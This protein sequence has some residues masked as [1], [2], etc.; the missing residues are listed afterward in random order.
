MGIFCAIS[1]RPFC[2]SSW[3]RATRERGGG[4]DRRRALRAQRRSVDL[5]QRL[6]RPHARH[7]AGSAEPAHPEAADGQLF[8]AL[9]RGPQDDGEGAG[10]GDPGGLDRG[11]LDTEGGRPRPGHGAER[12][13]QEPGLEAVQGYRRARRGVPETPARRRLAR[14]IGLEPMAPR[15]R[16]SGSTPPT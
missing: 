5:A 13:Q 2:R 15:C 8:P 16:A 9:P 3:V 11:G 10:L 14:V 1:P 4:C 6:P 12:H 7:A